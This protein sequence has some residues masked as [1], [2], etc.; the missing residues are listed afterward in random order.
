M[1]EKDKKYYWLKLHRDFFKR[2]D[3]QIIESM[4][5]GKDYILFYLKLLCESVDHN[6]NLRFSENIPYNE[7]MLATITRTNVDIV[8][9]AVKI[10]VEL[11]MMEIMT[12]GT[13][14]M[15]EVNKM[16]GSET[17]WAKKKREQKA[18]KLEQGFKHIRV[19]SEEQFALP[20][21]ETRFIDEKRYGGNGK[22][23]WDRAECKCEI[24]G[25]EENLCIHHNNGYSNELEDLILVCRKCHR[26]IENNKIGN[27]PTEIQQSPT[28]PSKSRER[29]KEIDKEIDRE[30]ETEKPSLVD[31]YQKLCPRLKPYSEKKLK[32]DLTEI[33]KEIQMNGMDIEKV[34]KMANESDFLAGVG[35]GWQA[36]FQWLMVV[37]NVRKVLAGNYKNKEANRKRT[38]EDQRTYDFDALERVMMKKRDKR[39]KGD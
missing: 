4:P 8:R 17:Y 22:K 38:F 13:Y 1:A 24:C 21:G 37:G 15:T 12:D 25:T 7:E 5:N 2:H 20:S 16:L 9:S 34:F 31:L 14:F 36:D 28:C 18:K 3:V 39:L 10:F 26:K 29:D 23:V 6:G 35:G 32:P 19:L 30:I 33:A 11:G 27:F